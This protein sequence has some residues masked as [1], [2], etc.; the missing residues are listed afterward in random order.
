[1]LRL[2]YT[3]ADIIL[4]PGRIEIADE[5]TPLP[6]FLMNLRRLV[7]KNEAEDEVGF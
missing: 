2:A 1:M 6:K 3:D 4:K 7:I 5:Y